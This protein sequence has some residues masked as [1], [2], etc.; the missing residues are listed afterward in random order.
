ME[1]KKPIIEMERLG[2]AK[3]DFDDK[4][5]VEAANCTKE[6]SD[7]AKILLEILAPSSIIRNL[8]ARLHVSWSR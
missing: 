8:S 7:E 4:K 5:I 1:Y 3:T 6:L 2:R